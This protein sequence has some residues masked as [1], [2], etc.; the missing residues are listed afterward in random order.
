MAQVSEAKARRILG[1]APDTEEEQASA[2]VDAAMD[3]L[4]AALDS[5]EGVAP[6]LGVFTTFEVV[7]T[8]LRHWDDSAIADAIAALPRGGEPAA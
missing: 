5:L 4:I 3:Q 1:I 6:N 2:D 7:N 8:L